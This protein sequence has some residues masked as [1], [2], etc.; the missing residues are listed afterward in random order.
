M[1]SGVVDCQSEIVWVT[2]VPTSDRAVVNDE[3]ED[4]RDDAV[5]RDDLARWVTLVGS[6]TPPVAET[7][8][9]V[10]PLSGMTATVPTRPPAIDVAVAE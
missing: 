9:D 8:V 3:A 1:L 5:A 2:V 10:L 7:D 4:R 6:I